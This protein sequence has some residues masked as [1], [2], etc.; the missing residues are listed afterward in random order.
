MNDKMTPFDVQSL[1]TLAIYYL[2]KLN[3]QRNNY[4]L[5]HDLLNSVDREA[6]SQYHLILKEGK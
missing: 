4:Y 6:I 2:H 5:S 1:K 3:I